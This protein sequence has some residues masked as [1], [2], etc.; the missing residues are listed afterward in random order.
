MSCCGGNN[1]LTD[2]DCNAIADQI[3][4]IAELPSLPTR[5]C[6]LMASI[7]GL[8]L[9]YGNYLIAVIIFLNYDIF[10][11]GGTL[12]LGFIIFGIIS[13]KI[14]NLSIPLSNLEFSYT[15]KEIITWYFSR[16]VC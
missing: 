15:D 16:Y 6:R 5:K 3:I 4:H 7:A 9:S 1:C 11:A 12:L 14:R 2:D 8:A 10:I 13:S